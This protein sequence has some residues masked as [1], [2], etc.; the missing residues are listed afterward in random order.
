MKGNLTDREII[1]IV[2]LYIGVTDGYLGDFTYRTHAEFYPE[3]CDLDINPAAYDGTT[4]QRFITILSSLEPLDQ[5]KVLRGVVA[6]FS[7]DEGPDTRKA[8]LVELQQVIKR[9]ES[10]PHVAGITPQITSEVVHRAIEDAEILIQSSGPTSAVDRVHTLLHGY[11]QAVCDDEWITYKRDDSMVALL[12]KIQAE[13][14]RF[15]DLGPRSQDV[16]RILNACATILDALMPLRNQASVAHPNKELLSEA[17]AM[18]VI[19]VG[20]SLL[21]YLNAKLS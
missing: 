18:L 16:G 15:T 11:L 20:R 10:A 7:P 6:R 8:S 13:H 12:R 19:N 14:P 3:Y 17:E 1:R 2:N 21:Q 5:A 4:R 9:L